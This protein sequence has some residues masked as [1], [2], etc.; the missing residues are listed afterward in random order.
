MKY[1]VIY[2]SQK[3][4]SLSIGDVIRFLELIKSKNFLVA[5]NKVN[6]S[7][8]RNFN[9]KSI[10]NIQ[11]LKKQKKNYKFV[12]L[13]LGLNLKN[14]FFDINDHISKN[15][16]A[17]TSTY[18]LIEKFKK[19]INFKKKNKNKFVLK[20]KS[21]VGINW[22]VPKNWKIKSYPMKSWKLLEKKIKKKYSLKITWQKKNNLN[23][24]VK[25]IK[26]CD[27]IISIVGLGVHIGSYFDKNIIMLSGPTDFYE[28]NKNK[29][30]LKITPKN[31]CKVHS[32]K[33]NIYYKNCN[34]MNN[35]KSEMILDKIHSVI[36]KK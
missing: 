25:W 35:I 36:N 14:S 23:N 21:K 28:S 5:T 27:T 18:K 22:M 20:K 34:C 26:S 30:I 4:Y 11:K 17:K 31:L 16:L 1:I 32:K 2:N 12:N 19:K 3:K 7:F 24:Y 15:N 9:K 13:T 6:G 8:F 29:K 10:I 33:I